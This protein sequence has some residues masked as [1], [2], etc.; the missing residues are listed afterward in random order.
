MR[1]VKET[2]EMHVLFDICG[3]DPAVANRIGFLNGLWT[4]LVGG[5]Q[6]A[7][8]ALKRKGINIPSEVEEEMLTKIKDQM[9]GHADTWDPR[10]PTW[11]ET[12]QPKPELKDPQARIPFP[13]R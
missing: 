3:R 6:A 10:V 8:Q 7:I 9:T 2:S 11:S 1:A 5:R 13:P 12:Q 4:G